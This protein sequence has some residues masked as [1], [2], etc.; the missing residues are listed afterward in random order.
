MHHFLSTIRNGSNEGIMQIGIKRFS[1]DQTLIH[2][3]NLLEKVKQ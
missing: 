1:L 3:K 2:L